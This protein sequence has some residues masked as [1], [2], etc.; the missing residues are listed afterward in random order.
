MEELLRSNDPVY[1][2]FVRH[3]LEEEG[4]DFLQLDDHM[5]A[6][7]GSIGVLPRRILVPR[8]DLARAKSVLGNAVLTQRL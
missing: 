5:S 6:L 4:I 2:S 7:E 8:D 3:V 1:L